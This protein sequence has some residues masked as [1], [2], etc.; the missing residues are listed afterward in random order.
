MIYLYVYSRCLNDKSLSAKKSC[1]NIPKYKTKNTL[2]HTMMTRNHK[3]L[4]KSD[5]GWPKHADLLQQAQCFITWY[6]VP[7]SGI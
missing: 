2:K 5:P 4:L 6:I 7:N 3:N 1:Y